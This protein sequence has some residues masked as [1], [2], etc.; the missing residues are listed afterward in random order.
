MPFELGQVCGICVRATHSGGTFVYGRIAGGADLELGKLVVR[1]L[2]RIPG[3][4]VASSN[5][6]SCLLATI[7]LVLGTQKKKHE[8]TNLSDNLRIRVQLDESP[9]KL[10]SCRVVIGFA[11]DSHGTSQRNLHVSRLHFAMSEVCS[12]LQ[13][14]LQVI[15]VLLSNLTARKL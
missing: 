3:I 8:N 4:T 11:E 13:T 9:S 10:S 6:L 15:W 1:Y 5:T 7:D 12:Q 2:N 14:S